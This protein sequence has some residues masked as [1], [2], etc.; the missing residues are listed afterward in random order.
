[1]LKNIN[2]RY[3]INEF[4]PIIR[5]HNKR[6]LIPVLSFLSFLVMSLLGLSYYSQQKII[7]YDNSKIIASK[8]LAAS[9]KLLVEKNKNIEL[10]ENTL[11]RKY[12]INFNNII[13]KS[14]FLDSGDRIDIF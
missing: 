2:A 1:M 4:N 10:E 14:Q 13:D 3:E 6:L 7:A 9:N 11:F 12:T 8:K 5:K